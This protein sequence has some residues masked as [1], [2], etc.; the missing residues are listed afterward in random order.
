MRVLS[1]APRF[2]RDIKR[3]CKPEKEVPEL[4]IYLLIKSLSLGEIKRGYL[5]G[6]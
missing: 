5:A 1:G 4:N 6:V 2:D 3:L